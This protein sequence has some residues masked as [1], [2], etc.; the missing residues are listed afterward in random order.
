MGSVA[1]PSGTNDFSFSKVNP[2]WTLSKNLSR[3]RKLVDGLAFVV[4]IPK[5]HQGDLGIPA[6]GQSL[7][8]NISDH[9]KPHRTRADESMYL[10]KTCT[11][12][13][14]APKS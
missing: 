13:F 4:A 9:N 12:A 11:N 3:W 8:E 5:N 14:R 2:R 1:L 10:L 7:D 6:P